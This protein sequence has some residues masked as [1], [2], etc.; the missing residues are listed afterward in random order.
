M[1]DSHRR[2]VF[3]SL[4]HQLILWSCSIS[5]DLLLLSLVSS[6]F[7]LCLTIPTLSPVLSSLPSHLVPTNLPQCPNLFKK[8][9]P[10]TCSLPFLTS[11]SLLD[12]LQSA[13][14]LQ[15]IHQSPTANKHHLV[16]S[17]DS[18]SIAS[19]SCTCKHV[20][21][22][23]ISLGLQ[24]T[25]HD[26]WLLFQTIQLHI[27]GRTILLKHKEDYVMDSPPQNSP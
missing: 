18:P 6:S 10:Y 16:T 22:G 23:K 7:T 14:C 8:F 17:R 24:S 15:M 5:Y 11:H 9:S 12:F 2:N 20:P 26:S 4:L 3:T 1:K 19:A 27:I 25:M 13:I 21:C